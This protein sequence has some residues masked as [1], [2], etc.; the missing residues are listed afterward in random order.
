MSLRDTSRFKTVARSHHKIKTGN[1]YVFMIFSNIP[2]CVTPFW[3]K[4]TQFEQMSFGWHLRGMAPIP[5]IGS[6]SNIHMAFWADPSL[7]IWIQELVGYLSWIISRARD[8]CRAG[9]CFPFPSSQGT[10]SLIWGRRRSETYADGCKFPSFRSKTLALACSL[11][12]SG[13]DISA[14]A[15]VC[16]EVFDEEGEMEVLTLFQ[17]EPVLSV[18]SLSLIAQGL[19]FFPFLR[20]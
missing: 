14:W 6:S 20:L 4:T 10:F 18:L 2:W 5:N 1:L 17:F 13:F 19:Q 7:K 12:G 16:S 3:E 9:S 15:W 11:Y 8:F